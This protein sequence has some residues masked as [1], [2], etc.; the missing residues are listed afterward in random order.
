MRLGHCSPDVLTLLLD[1]IICGSG[2][3]LLRSPIQGEGSSSNPPST[4]KS[5]FSFRSFLLSIIFFKVVKIKMKS[6][7][8]NSR[9]KSR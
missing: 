3:L 7:G 1:Y 6:C 9:L 4:C 2:G 8:S 5:L